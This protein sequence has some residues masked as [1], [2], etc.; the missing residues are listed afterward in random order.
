VVLDGLVDGGRLFSCLRELT[1]G[2]APGSGAPEPAGGLEFGRFQ[3]LPLD[4]DLAGADLEVE[5][6][7]AEAGSSEAQSC[8]A[9]RASA[10]AVRV[11]L[12]GSGAAA[13]ADAG[14]I[15]APVPRGARLAG[16]VTLARGS[17][18]AGRN[19]AL[20]ATGCAAPETLAEVDVCGRPDALTRARAELVLVEF[21]AE[22]TEGGR[23]FGLQFLNASRAL[24]L[25]DVSL[26]VGGPSDRSVPFVSG[27]SF[28][29]LRPRAVAT[30]EQPL[31]L[32][33]R[34]RGGPN[35]VAYNQLWADTLEASALELEPG[36]NY[37][38]ASVG[39]AASVDGLGSS[40]R[41]VLI[42]AD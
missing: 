6:Y 25:A 38:L 4:W 12:A 18:F 3:R 28:G 7:S 31:A 27:V 11:A 40:P 5:L 41:L 8:E 30:V 13:G 23:Y 14:A 29:V 17:L 22:S 10:D 37:L 21:G 2:Q 35:V 34:G 26:Q 32:E 39:P 24:G 15:P 9:L 36:K 16:S 33:L 1:S 19:Y 42:P 20:V